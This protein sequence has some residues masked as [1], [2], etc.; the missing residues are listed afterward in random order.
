MER[1]KTDQPA[2]TTPVRFRHSRIGFTKETE[3]R[4]FFAMTLIMLIAGI[5]Y[6][7]GVW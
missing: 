5:L 6:K 1:K 3:R 4:V 7:T 2:D